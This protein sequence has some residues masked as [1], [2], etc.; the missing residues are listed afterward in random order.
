MLDVFV[1]SLC[2]MSEYYKTVTRSLNIDNS[3]IS[4]MFSLATIKIMLFLTDL[5]AGEIL[6]QILIRQFE[7]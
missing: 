5:P 4:R 1:V 2:K 7:V 6:L 3:A